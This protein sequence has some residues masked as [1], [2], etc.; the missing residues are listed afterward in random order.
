MIK[1]IAT[2]V[3]GTL[4]KDSS[5]EIYPEML[6]VI[7]TLTD[8]GCHFFVASGRSCPGIRYMF[9]EVA[10]RIGY[11]ADNGAHIHYRGQD[12]SFSEMD[13]EVANRIILE[14]RLNVP[15]VNIMVSRPGVSLVET[16]DE[17]FNAL[18]RDGYHNKYKV[19]EDLLKEDGPFIKV[20][21]H[22]WG[23]IRSLG[24]SSLIPSWSR[25]VKSCMAGEE[26]VDCMDKSVNKGNA[27]RFVQ[28]YFHVSHEETMAFGD[29]NNDVE[30]LLSAGESYAVETAREEVK[31]AAKHICPSYHDKG[32]YQV[33]KNLAARQEK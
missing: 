11:I 28:D 18:M 25:W 8:N 24:E 32:V 23:S 20:A 22:K 13:R 1:L 26:W 2:D 4:V 5:P 7:R 9:R 16:K 6:D 15:G 3:D 10:D 21:L 19:V 14:A 30:M 12:L 17:K 33:L 31:K 27:L 29:N